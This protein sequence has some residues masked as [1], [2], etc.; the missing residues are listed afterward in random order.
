[1][2]PNVPRAEVGATLFDCPLG[3]ALV[4]WTTTGVLDLRLPDPADGERRANVDIGVYDDRGPETS[5]GRRSRDSSPGKSVVSLV[6]TRRAPRWIESSIQRIDAHLRGFLDDL[7]DI[8]LDLPK[9]ARRFDLDIWAATRE[10]PPG[11][12]I[13]YGE[14]AEEAG[15]PGAARAAGG[16]L[17]RVPMDLL[18][19][20]HRVIAAGR[21]P[22]GWTGGS[23]VATKIRLL[24]LEGVDLFG[25]SFEQAVDTSNGR[26]VRFEP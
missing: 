25:A 18:V 26:G 21:R 5:D 9:D 14:L 10:V 22:G 19:P 13:T 3:T 4:A 20:A 23:G 2:P 15:H 1:M 17:R 11:L 12:T 16:A 6:P 24:E 7:L 8:P